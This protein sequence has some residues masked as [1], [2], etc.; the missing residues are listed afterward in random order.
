MS[1]PLVVTKRYEDQRFTSWRQPATQTNRDTNR[2]KTLARSNQPRTSESYQRQDDVFEYEVKHLYCLECCCQYSIISESEL[3]ATEKTVWCAAHPTKSS[4]VF[5][6][7]SSFRRVTLR[8]VMQHFTSN[9]TDQCQNGSS[10]LDRLGFLP[11]T[12]G[13]RSQQHITL[14]S[15]LINKPKFLKAT[16]HAEIRK[17]EI[18]RSM[19]VKAL[20]W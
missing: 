3:Q 13:Q 19:V 16:R 18:P 7:F 4:N 12:H 14:K 8:Q 2:D 5:Q 15:F 6:K 11:P 17:I 10:N 1:I 9:G 20:S